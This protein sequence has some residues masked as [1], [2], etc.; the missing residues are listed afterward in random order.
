MALV[1]EFG[2]GGAS[3]LSSLVDATQ[4]ALAAQVGALQDGDVSEAS[5]TIGSSILTQSV[6]VGAVGSA[7]SGTGGTVK[8]E[9]DPSANAYDF[10]VT[11][12]WNSVKNVKAVSDDSENVTF[13]NFVHVDVILGGVEASTVNIMDAKRGNVVT[14]QGND[15]VNLTTLTNDAGWSNA[16]TINTNGGDDNIVI[17]AGNTGVAGAGVTNGSLTTF[18]INSGTGVDTID[19]SA[20]SAKASFVTGGKGA[21][22]MMASGGVDTFVFAVGD[23]GTKLSTADVITGFGVNDKLDLYGVAA[24]WTAVDQGGGEFIVTNLLDNAKIIVEGD[25]SGSWFI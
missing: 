21:D 16:F 4:A 18:T 19:L 20:I 10:D 7:G 25:L 11:S 23:T 5:D 1:V 8:I 6:A 15:T 9:F 12:A 3:T 22:L 2:N 14:G 24:N 17:G 13:S